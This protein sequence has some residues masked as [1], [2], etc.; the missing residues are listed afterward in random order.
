MLK[1][2]CLSSNWNTNNPHF[3]DVSCEISQA[4]PLKQNLSHTT[5]PCPQHPEEEQWR[6]FNPEISSK[7]TS[8]ISVILNNIVSN[9]R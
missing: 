1:K 2:I 7:F 4:Q 9:T 5:D 8:G 3:N 6:H